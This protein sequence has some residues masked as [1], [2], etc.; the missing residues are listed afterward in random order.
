M[1]KVKLGQICIDSG[2]VV[3]ADPGL[4]KDRNRDA[5][6]NETHTDE[7]LR[8]MDKEGNGGEIGCM[9]VVETGWGDGMYDVIAHVDNMGKTTK[10]EINFM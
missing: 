6:F 5:T 1:K 2:C 3:L 7:I 8:Q 10:I 4:I 9:V